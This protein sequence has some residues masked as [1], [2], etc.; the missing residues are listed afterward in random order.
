MLYVGEQVVKQYRVPSPTQEA[1]LNAFEEEGWPTRI[2]DPLRPKPDQD[3]KRH[4]HETIRR[5][6]RNRRA[7]LIHFSGDGTGAG[8]LWELTPAGRLAVGRRRAA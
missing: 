5:L 4:L 8:V 6:N 1:V 3:A 2:D 7:K